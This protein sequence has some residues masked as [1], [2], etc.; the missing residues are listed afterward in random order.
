MR[1]RDHTCD[2]QAVF[3]ELCQ[4]GGLRFIRRTSRKDGR[5]MVVEESPWVIAAEADILW[6]RLLEG[7]AR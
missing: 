4:S 3:Y 2:C 7:R 6:R 5:R 1:V